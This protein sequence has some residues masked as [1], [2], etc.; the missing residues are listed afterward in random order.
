MA[1]NITQAQAFCIATACLQVP[2]FS[3]RARPFS[4]ISI[5]NNLHKRQSSNKLNLFKPSLLFSGGLD[6]QR[7]RWWNRY[8]D[9]FNQH[10][11]F[12]LPTIEHQQSSDFQHKMLSHHRNWR[13]NEDDKNSSWLKDLLKQ[14]ATNYNSVALDSPLN[15]D[16]FYVN[17]SNNDSNKTNAPEQANSTTTETTSNPAPATPVTNPK[18]ESTTKV[19]IT[20]TTTQKTFTPQ[21]SP[22][23]ITLKPTT[24]KTLSNYP[25]FNQLHAQILGDHYH[26]PLVLPVLPT[27]PFIYPFTWKAYEALDESNNQRQQVQ[28]HWLAGQVANL[29]RR[30]SSNLTKKKLNLIDM[31]QSISNLNGQ[32]AQLK[33]PSNL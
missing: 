7:N 30:V 27:T 21:S 2:I 8:N 19:D 5:A 20:T 25:N 26:R 16:V 10:R 24:E 22:V 33:L 3:P 29:M 28:I 17:E 1:T 11:D 31:W 18:L 13:L 15:Q 14:K 6:R 12:S 23:A 9:Q 4:T 32:S